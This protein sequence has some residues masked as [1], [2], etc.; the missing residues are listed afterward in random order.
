MR[1][2]KKCVYVVRKSNNRVFCVSEEH[3]ENYK[4]Q[5][6]LA[7]IYPIAT[8]VDEKVQVPENSVTQAEEVPKP[9]VHKKPLGRP[10]NK[11]KK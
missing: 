9:I 10:A 6:D 3:Y 11:N 2:I 4:D 7:D 8:I 1:N 5:Y